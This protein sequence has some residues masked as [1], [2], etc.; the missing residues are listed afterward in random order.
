MLGRE[1]KRKK[2][3]KCKLFSDTYK[4]TN[5]IPP[6]WPPLIIIISQRLYFQIPSC[7][8][9]VQ[10][11]GDL[12]GFNIWN[13]KEHKYSVHN[14]RIYMP[15]D[16][17]D[18]ELCLLDHKLFV[19]HTWRESSVPGREI[20]NSYEE[21]MLQRNGRLVRF[22][23]GSGFSFSACVL[24]TR[25]VSSCLHS[26][27]VPLYP[28]CVYVLGFP[29]GTVGV[30]REPACQCRRYKRWR[31]N[32]WVRM[33]PWRRKWQPT[34]VFLPGKYP[35]TEEPG[36]LYSPWGSQRVGHDWV[37]THTLS[38]RCAVTW[39]LMSFR[40]K[41]QD[42]QIGLFHR[43]TGDVFWS[44]VW[45]ASL[46]QRVRSVAAAQT[47][48]LARE[49]RM[50]DCLCPS[51]P[52]SREH[53]NHWR[54]LAAA[55]PQLSAGIASPSELTCLCQQLVS[56]SVSMPWECLQHLLPLQSVIWDFQM[57]LLHI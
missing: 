15:K 5:P 42:K 32:L 43:K 55:G 9:G 14:S 22:D 53:Y 28:G 10:E 21:K 24:D 29:D 20:I 51:Q 11:S 19:S 46:S 50:L 16:I 23:Q 57:S 1:Q 30:G 45:L 52:R 26:L 47:Q 17:M 18:K 33:I 35:W 25:M 8:E 7:R 48:M 56:A 36:R 49:R 41:L 2:K 13:L 44:D 27:R 37:H 39:S 34:P 4:G 54:A 3:R 31:L 38:F 6:S 12:L 40:V